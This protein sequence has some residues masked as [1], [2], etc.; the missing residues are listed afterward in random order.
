MSARALPIVSF[1]PHSSPTKKVLY[2]IKPFL[3]FYR[4]GGQGLKAEVTC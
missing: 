4:G 3:T 1:N 2:I